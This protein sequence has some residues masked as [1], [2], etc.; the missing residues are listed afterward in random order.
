MAE[1]DKEG[2]RIAI[3][4]IISARLISYEMVCA[5]PRVAP[6]VEYFLLEAQPER[7][8]G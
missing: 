4:K 5:I 7:N 1:K 3:D 6:K 2:V 8:K